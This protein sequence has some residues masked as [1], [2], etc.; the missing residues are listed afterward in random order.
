MM[1]INR[2]YGN[3]FGGLNKFA[4]VTPTTTIKNKEETPAQK[5]LRDL[6]LIKL[7]SGDRLRK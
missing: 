7:L 6:M 3:N 4:I 2:L 5:Q 1:F